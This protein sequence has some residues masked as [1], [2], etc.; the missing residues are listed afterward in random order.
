MTTKRVETWKK[1]KRK[2]QTRD[3]GTGTQCLESVQRGIR[4]MDRVGTGK[5]GRSKRNSNSSRCRRLYLFSPRRAQAV[6]STSPV[7]LRA[8]GSS[9]SSRFFRAILGRGESKNEDT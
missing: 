4:E 2:I 1:K 3:T 5:A 7:L 6:A 9:R 8:D